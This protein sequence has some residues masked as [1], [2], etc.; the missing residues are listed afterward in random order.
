MR[1]WV[2]LELNDSCTVTKIVLYV[3]DVLMTPYLPI[4]DCLGQLKGETKEE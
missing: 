3:L 4:G 2:L 1:R